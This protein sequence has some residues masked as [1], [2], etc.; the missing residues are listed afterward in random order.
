M[1]DD[2][3]QRFIEGEV[4]RSHARRGGVEEPQRR[5]RKEP[6]AVGSTD[7]KPYSYFI[8]GAESCRINWWDNQ[9][10]DRRSGTSF[11]Y[12][13]LVRIG[14]DEVQPGSGMMMMYLFLADVNYQLD[15][16]HLWPLIDCLS[17][18]ECAE[19]NVFSPAVHRA[20]MGELLSLGEPILTRVQS[21]D[22][23]LMTSQ[24]VQN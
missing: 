14:W 16:Y 1:T 22:G 13:T 11:H 20:T 18:F 10:G 9:R 3:F 2:K 4:A 21:S 24:S 7:Y 23:L 5:T 15:G 17:H 19:M 6:V 8:Q 12:R